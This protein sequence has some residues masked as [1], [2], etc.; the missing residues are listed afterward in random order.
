MRLARITALTSG[1]A[2][3][4]CRFYALQGSPLSR[5]EHLPGPH[6][7]ALEILVSRYPSDLAAHNAFVRLD[8][9]E[10]TNPQQASIV[11]QAPGLCF[12]TSFDAAD[13]G[14]DWACAFSKGKL[15]VVLRTVVTKS[16]LNVILV[17]RAVAARL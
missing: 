14:K 7:P 6:Q 16:A 5:S 13:K 10:G 1:G 9:A 2:T 17:S 3:V 8:Q 11:G 12:Q 4:G 15:M